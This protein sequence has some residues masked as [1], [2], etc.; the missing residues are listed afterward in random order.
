MSD[1]G[2][3]KVEVTSIDG[4]LTHPFKRSDTIGEVH[5]FSYD[6]LVRDKTTVPFTA[7]TIE[8]NSQPVSD[9][10]TLGSL[11]SAADNKEHEK[12]K[13]EGK[14]TLALTWVSQGGQRIAR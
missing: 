7:T 13:D 8:F 9:A 4:N 2:N 10:E 12:N 3:I 14:L 11:A 6:R 5:R 1:S